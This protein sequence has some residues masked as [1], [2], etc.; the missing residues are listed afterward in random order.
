MSTKP[1]AR[2]DVAR[3]ARLK[4]DELS[5][6]E[7]S[8]AQ[9]AQ[10]ACGGLDNKEADP[11]ELNAEMIEFKKAIALLD[12]PYQAYVLDCVIHL[13]NTSFSIG[14][15]SA[16]DIA[17]MRLGGRKSGRTRSQQM[18]AW[19]GQV[20]SKAQ[21]LLKQD[22]SLTLPKLAE[23]ICEMPR[24]AGEVGLSAGYRSVYNYLL[25][26]RREKML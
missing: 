18:E 8:L 14:R 22:D 24:C 10:K 9:I 16:K 1:H 5:T 20:F 26:L 21:L 17:K 19:K 11:Q 4:H 3:S 25:Q 13:L 6:L 15:L 7:A 23:K 12:L 2:S